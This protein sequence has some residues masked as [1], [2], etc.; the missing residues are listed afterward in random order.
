LADA[1]KRVGTSWG[2]Y[3]QGTGSLLSPQNLGP[4][5][6]EAVKKSQNPNPKE[7]RCGVEFFLP[8]SAESWDFF[9]E[10]SGR[11]QLMGTIPG[12][13]QQKKAK[14]TKKRKLRFRGRTGEGAVEYLSVVDAEGKCGVLDAE[15]RNG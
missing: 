13:D 5:A 4:K 8:G 11:S 1:R 12:E 2:I 15:C 14:I 3:L 6:R 10:I 9:G 7:D